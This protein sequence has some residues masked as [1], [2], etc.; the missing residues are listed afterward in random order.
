M[1]PKLHTKHVGVKRSPYKANDKSQ[2][3]RVFNNSTNQSPVMSAIICLLSTLFCLS[4]LTMILFYSQLQAA[5][6]EFG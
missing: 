1:P 4:L 2:R 5:E 6:Q 3:S